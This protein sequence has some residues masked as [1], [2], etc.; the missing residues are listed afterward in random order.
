MGCSGVPTQI[1]AR[2]GLA[3]EKQEFELQP[4]EFDF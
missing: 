3:A 1:A 2:E 4:G